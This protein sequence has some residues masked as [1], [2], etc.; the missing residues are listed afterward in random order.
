MVKE[1]SKGYSSYLVFLGNAWLRTKCLLTG[2]HEWYKCNGK[3]CCKK[4][5]KI[6]ELS[7]KEKV[8][9]MKMGNFFTKNF[10]F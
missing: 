9:N 5:Y 4:C 2:S 7:E 8:L 10:F 1:I 6:K 3:I